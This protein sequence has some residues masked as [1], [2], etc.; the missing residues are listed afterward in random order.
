MY[1]FLLFFTL[2]PIEILPKKI[3]SDLEKLMVRC[4]DLRTIAKLKEACSFSLM[5]S[6]NHSSIL[7]PRSFI[8]QKMVFLDELSS[9]FVYLHFTEKLKKLP[10]S[11]QERQ[12]FFTMMDAT[13]PQKFY[14]PNPSQASASFFSGS[15]MK[16][17]VTGT[18]SFFSPQTNME[19]RTTIMMRNIPNRYDVHLLL[20]LIRP[21]F[22]GSFDF[23]Y[24]P[25][26][27]KVSALSLRL[28]YPQKGNSF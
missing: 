3:K 12:P 16:P 13:S 27:F 10:S 24:V 22:N 9:S 21:E 2:L 26:D 23:V 5:A 15:P 18:A 14:S 17:I 28:S 20:E 1:S 11:S 25:I 7:S 4:V 6:Q 19:M 8:L